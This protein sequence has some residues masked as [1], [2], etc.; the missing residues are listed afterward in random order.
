MK[1]TR[2]IFSND[3]QTASKLSCRR[4]KAET[5]IRNILAPKSVNDFVKILSSS[6]NT[7]R[8]FSTNASNKGNRKIFPVCLR[9]FDPNEGVQW[10]VRQIFKLLFIYLYF[11]F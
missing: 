2:Q 11:Y 1:L 8:F 3:L 10:K 6:E 7:K 4:T 9:Y 5:F